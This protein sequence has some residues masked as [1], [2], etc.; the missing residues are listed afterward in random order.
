MHFFAHPQAFLFW[1]RVFSR[2]LGYRANRGAASTHGVNWAPA[3]LRGACSERSNASELASKLTIA[4][5]RARANQTHGNPR[6]RMTSTFL[7]V[8]LCI[9]VRTPG[10]ATLQQ[11]PCLKLFPLWQQR[12]M[13]LRVSVNACACVSV[14][15]PLDLPAHTI[16]C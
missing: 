9:T 14:C 4:F 10:A 3:G 1:P 16:R 13:L 7:H 6:N 12:T 15:V 2:A 5:P 8:L 11:Q